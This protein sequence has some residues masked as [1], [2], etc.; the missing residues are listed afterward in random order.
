MSYIHREL[1]NGGWQALSLME[2][3]ANIGSEVERAVVWASKR[4][5]NGRKKPYKIRYWQLGN[6]PNLYQPGIPERWAEILRVGYQAAYFAGTSLSFV[7]PGKADAF[8]LGI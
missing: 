4:A 5:E 7:V 2:Q 6:E 3:M 8:L 1:A